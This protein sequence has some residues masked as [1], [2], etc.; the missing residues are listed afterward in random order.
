MKLEIGQFGH[1][2]AVDPRKVVL[3]TPFTIGGIG[4]DLASFG[5]FLSDLAGADR[6]TQY[7]AGCCDGR[8]DEIEAQRAAQRLKDEECILLM[9][10]DIM[11]RRAARMGD[12]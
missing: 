5:K 2:Y 11:K 12:G 4:A 10:D 1:D 6:L 8:D 9:A 3:Q 7:V